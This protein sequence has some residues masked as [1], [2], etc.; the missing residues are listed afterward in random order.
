MPDIRFPDPHTLFTI[1]AR[2]MILKIGFC[3]SDPGPAPLCAKEMKIPNRQI[4]DQP[5]A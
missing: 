2:L 3:K 5:M 1:K 4:A